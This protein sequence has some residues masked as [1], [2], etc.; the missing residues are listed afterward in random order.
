MVTCWQ[1][2]II[3]YNNNIYQTR[4]TIGMDWSCKEMRKRAAAT[5]RHIPARKPQPPR[6]DPRNR[7]RPKQS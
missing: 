4:Y 3:A 7:D 1:E 5:A 2:T 6:A